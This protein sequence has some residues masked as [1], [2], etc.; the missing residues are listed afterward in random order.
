[1]KANPHP[2][3]PWA[4]NPYVPT[5]KEWEERKEDQ[6]AFAFLARFYN[7][8]NPADVT[9]AQFAT[10]HRGVK[11]HRNWEKGEH[12]E[13]SWIERNCLPGTITVHDKA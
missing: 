12:P 4:D 1:V 10:L 7:G 11:W 9:F 8:V 2:K 6:M 13:G 3:P 5:G